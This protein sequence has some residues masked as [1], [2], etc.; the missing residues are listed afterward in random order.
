MHFD[1]Q[2]KDVDLE[3]QSSDTF[4][5]DVP[6]WERNLDFNPEKVNCYETETWVTVSGGAPSFTA[7][8]VSAELVLEGA[9]FDLKTLILRDP[10]L[11]VAG[12]LGKNKSEWEY[13]MAH[14]G[15]DEQI[16]TSVRKWLGD[17]VDIVEFFYTF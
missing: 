1:L 15:M 6:K 13:V 17:G 8:N 2:V 12:Q 7:Q 11:F 14:S 3:L 9:D 16:L 10:N 4:H 5:Y